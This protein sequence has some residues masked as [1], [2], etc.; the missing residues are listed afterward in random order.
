MEILFTQLG[1]QQERRR[2]ARTTT[3]VIT[4]GKVAMAPQDN[5]L[6]P[7]RPYTTEE[8]LSGRKTYYATTWLETMVE[9]S[10]AGSVAELAA[11]IQHNADLHAAMQTGLSAISVR[12]ILPA[13]SPELFMGFTGTAPSTGQHVSTPTLTGTQ[14]D[15]QSRLDAAIPGASG[16]PDDQTFARACLISWRQLVDRAARLEPQTVHHWQ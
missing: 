10:G 1:L 2:H 11:H 7:Q 14:L 6:G 9:H 15:L 16:N 12:P 8:P 13:L 4:A 5:L 3:L